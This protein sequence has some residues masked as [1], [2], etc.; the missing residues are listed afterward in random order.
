MAV[1]MSNLIE[2]RKLNFFSDKKDTSDHTPIVTKVILLDV[3]TTGT[4]LG[5]FPTN[6]LLMFLAELFFIPALVFL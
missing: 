2:L 3:W 5:L 6:I 1:S 4:H